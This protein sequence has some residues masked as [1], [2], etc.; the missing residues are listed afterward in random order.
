MGAS[1]AGSETGGVTSPAGF[2]DA[3][4]GTSASFSVS[5]ARPVHPAA[6]ATEI[7]SKHKRFSMMF[8]PAWLLSEP[9]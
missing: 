3:G 4:G 7:T 2:Q 8:L 9:G 1:V 6:N 5:W